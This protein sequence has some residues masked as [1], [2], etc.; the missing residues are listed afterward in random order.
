MI[1]VLVVLVLLV[2]GSLVLVQGCYM[3]QCFAV[4][5]PREDAH[6]ND[7]LLTY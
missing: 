5:Q 7:R 4:G 1:E 2:G 6:F 3:R